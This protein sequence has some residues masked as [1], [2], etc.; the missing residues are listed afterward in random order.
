MQRQQEVLSP[1]SVPDLIGS[2]FEKTTKLRIPLSVHIDLTMRCNERCIHCYRVIERRPE[3]TTAELQALLD[4]L[5]RA[6]TLYLTFSGGEVLLRQDLFGLIA[7]ARRRHFDVRLKSNALLITPAKAARLRA[8]GVRQVDISIYS[9]EP[10]VHDWVT[11]VPGSLERTLAGAAWLRDAGITVKLNCPLM[12]QNVGQYRQLRALAERLGVL[13]GFDPM[14]TAK[15][16]GDQSPVPLRITRQQLSQVLQDSTLN[17]DH[18]TPAPPEPGPDWTRPDLD[19]IACG[20]GHNACYISAYGDVMPCVALPIACGNVREAPFAEIWHR[21]P[22]MMRV[23]SI[24]IRDL[25]TCSTCTASPFCTRCPG[26]ALVEG[27]D[28]YGPSPANCEHALAAAQLAGS[29][30]VPAG[31][32]SRPAESSPP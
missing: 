22:E 14:I 16:D 9:A 13:C 26:Q 3:L 5:A 10:A 6:G 25:H 32:R 7:Y 27:N 28:L 20:A 17:P 21:S 8:L 23:R 19:D 1:S 11:K 30:V 4:D 15:N 29:S 31:M 18:G 24:R 2:L 12:K